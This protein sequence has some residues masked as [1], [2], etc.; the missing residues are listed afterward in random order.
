MIQTIFI[1]HRGK[2]VKLISSTLEQRKNEHFS[3]AENEHMETSSTHL[4]VAL[5][6]I[7]VRAMEATKTTR[8]VAAQLL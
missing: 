5:A 3:A 8:S 2:V 6:A 4:V 1:F 7:R